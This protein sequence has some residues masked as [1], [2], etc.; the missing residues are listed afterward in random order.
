MMP[1]VPPPLEAMPLLNFFLPLLSKYFVG[2]VFIDLRFENIE[3]KIG[4]AVSFVCYDCDLIK[5]DNICLITCQNKTGHRT[6][7]I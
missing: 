5:R 2:S 1:P 7:S 4:I 6:K 3:F